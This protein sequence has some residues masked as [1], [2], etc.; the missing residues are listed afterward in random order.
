[1]TDDDII[2]A[3]FPAFTEWLN[4]CASSTSLVSEHDRLR[5]TNLMRRGAPIDLTIDH[6][7]GRLEEEARGFFDFCK[8]TFLRIPGLKYGKEN[9]PPL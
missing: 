1:M 2:A 5:G 6:A 7:T 8:D 9:L 3:N 4:M